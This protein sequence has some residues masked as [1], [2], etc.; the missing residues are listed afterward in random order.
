MSKILIGALV[1]A[2]VAG[3]VYY[4]YNNQEEVEEQLGSLKDKAS[5][6]LGKAKKQF[7]KQSEDAQAWAQS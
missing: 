7:S 6:A 5:D 1:C 3:V 4:V 2:A